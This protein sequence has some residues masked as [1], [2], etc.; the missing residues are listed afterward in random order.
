MKRGLALLACAFALVANEVRA[1]TPPSFWDRARDVRVGS[2]WA[3]HA[4]VS[5]LLSLDGGV[6][7]LRVRSLGLERARALLEEAGAEASPDA[8]LRYDLGEVYEALAHHA[9]AAEVLEGALVLA[10]QHP[11]AQR[12]WMTLALAHAKLGHQSSERDAWEQY[13]P[14][15]VDDRSR[16]S[17]ILNL[18]EAEM[19]VGNL[20]E[21]VD[22]YREAV[23]LAGSLPTSPSA[24]ETG[25]LAVWGLAVALDRAGDPR[26]A[27]EQATLATRMDPG[28]AL[29]G[30]G[31]NVFFVPAYERLW[32]L[33]LG[34]TAH[35]REETEPTAA[36]RK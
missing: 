9:R 21:A 28:E 20:V 4:R 6:G 24:V 16:A 13:L 23:Q 5:E 26:G 29:I 33:A 18:A 15:V 35:A 36:A 14:L 2:R 27:I 3:L 31:Q 19:H 8:T 10:P 22:R 17:A 11:A 34:A 1:D 32:Y 7:G 30:H 12:A 25:I